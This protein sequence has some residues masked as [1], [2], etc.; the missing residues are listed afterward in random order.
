MCVCVCDLGQL[1]V[2]GMGETRRSPLPRGHH[3]GQLPHEPPP[4]VPV[5]RR[6]HSAQ[7]RERLCAGL[8]RGGPQVQVLGGELRIH[9]SCYGDVYLS[10]QLAQ[11]KGKGGRETK[12]LGGI[13][14]FL[15]SYNSGGHHNFL[16][17]RCPLVVGSVVD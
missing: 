1:A 14:H 2:Q 9:V 11:G 4:H 8:L 15:V 5:Q 13:V 16:V 7:Q 17:I 12:D 10:E 3:A 6:H